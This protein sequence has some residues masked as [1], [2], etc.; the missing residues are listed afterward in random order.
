MPGYN[1]YVLYLYMD[2]YKKI[3]DKHKIIISI[4][5]ILIFM[6]MDASKM[7]EIIRV[8]LIFYILL[9]IWFLV[10]H[11]KRKHKKFHII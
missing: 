1:F 11:H 4:L 6:I 9:H 3:S 2:T 10:I 7:Y 5:L 8:H